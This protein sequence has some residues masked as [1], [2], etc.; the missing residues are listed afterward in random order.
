MCL[1]MCVFFFSSRRRHTRCA[2]VTGVQTCALPI[3]PL[4][5]P[6]M[7][8]EMAARYGDSARHRISGGEHYPA[9]LKPDR[10]NAMLRD[11]HATIAAVETSRKSE[12]EMAFFKLNGEYVRTYVDPDK[13]IL[14]VSCRAHV[15]QY[16]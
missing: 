13:Q 14:R 3:Y 10:Y 2:L 5:D 4:I 8:D 1:L 16:V 6:S 11:Y 7:Q 12:S 9:V 15:R